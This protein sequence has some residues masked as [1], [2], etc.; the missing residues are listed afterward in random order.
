MYLSGV[1][2]K[3]KGIIEFGDITAD[4]V[5]LKW[6]PPEDNGGCDITNYVIEKKET[7]HDSWTAVTANCI[8]EEYNV[9]RLAPKCE[10]IFRIAAEN[11]YGLGDFAISDR[12]VSRYP[13]RYC[14]HNVIYMSFLSTDLQPKMGR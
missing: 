9:L 13:F 5:F 1:P 10:Y 14:S 11:K 2:K 3:I 8:G 4:S 12:V 6:S 7:G